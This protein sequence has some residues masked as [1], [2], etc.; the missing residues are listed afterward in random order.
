M[1]AITMSFY[2][3]CPGYSHSSGHQHH[4][5]LDS[6]S[7]SLSPPQ[8]CRLTF[9]PDSSAGAPPSSDPTVDKLNPPL[10]SNPGPQPTVPA[11]YDCPSPKHPHSVHLNH[12]CP[13]TQLHH[14]CP[15]VLSS[16]WNALPHTSHSKTPTLP[17]SLSLDGPFLWGHPSTS[18]CWEDY[19]FCLQGTSIHSCSPSPAVMPGVL[20]P[21]WEQP[22]SRQVSF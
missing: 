8:G 13:R 18:G 17:S 6:S 2:D 19:A 7:N 12:A 16:S 9:L 20:F 1:W 14:T 5:D 15:L 4:P 21:H 10:G 3:S 11:G 22:E